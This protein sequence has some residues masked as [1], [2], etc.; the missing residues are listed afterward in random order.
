MLW[1]LHVCPLLV[2]PSPCP[3]AA[4]RASLCPLWMHETCGQG[5]RKTLLTAVRG[6]AG[7]WATH[8]V[9]SGFV[10]SSRQNVSQAPSRSGNS[11]VPSIYLQHNNLLRETLQYPA[12]REHFCFSQVRA[13]QSLTTGDRYSIQEGPWLLK[14]KIQLNGITVLPYLRYLIRSHMP[15]KS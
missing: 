6:R 13:L 15:R 8:T 3:P 11:A 7:A 2:T 14:L 4:A 5:W 9:V 10:C 12:K 1:L